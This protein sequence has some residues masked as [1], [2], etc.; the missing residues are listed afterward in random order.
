MTAVLA[1]GRNTM[2]KKRGVGLTFAPPTATVD[3][4]TAS[5]SRRDLGLTISI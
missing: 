5:L 2:V 3:L 4:I 1:P